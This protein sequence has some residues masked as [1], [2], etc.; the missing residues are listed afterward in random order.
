MSQGIAA[1]PYLQFTTVALES[2]DIEFSW[3]DDEG[4]AGSE[5]QRLVVTG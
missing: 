4:V 1:N 2:G 3:V 5:R